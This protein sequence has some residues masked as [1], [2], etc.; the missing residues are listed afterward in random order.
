MANRHDQVEISLDILRDSYCFIEWSYK[1]PWELTRESSI[2]SK[3]MGELFQVSK[4]DQP[5]V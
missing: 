2:I 1:E 5:T 4:K 3:Q